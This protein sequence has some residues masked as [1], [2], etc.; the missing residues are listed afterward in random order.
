MK[1][2]YKCIKDVMNEQGKKICE[3]GKAYICFMSDK[4][5]VWVCLF[6]FTG[7]RLFLDYDSFKNHFE[8]VKNIEWLWFNCKKDLYVIDKKLIFLKK[9]TY[10]GHNYGVSS[11]AVYLNKNPLKVHIL[12]KGFAE[13]SFDVVEAVT[14]KE[15]YK[16]IKDITDEYDITNIH[17][18]VLCKKDKIY[19]CKVIDGD[20][21]VYDDNI[22]EYPFLIEVNEFN[23]CFEKVE[24]T[25]EDSDP[26]KIQIDGDHYKDCAIQPIRFIEMNKLGFTQ[27]N[28]V[29]RITRYRKPTGKGLKDLQKI[30]HE[31][32]LLQK[33]VKEQEQ[34][35]TFKVNRHPMVIH[36]D[37]YIRENEIQGLEAD[38]I[39]LIVVYDRNISEY[40]KTMESYDYGFDKPIYSPIYIL[41]RKRTD[42]LEEIIEKVDSLIDDW[43]E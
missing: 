27:G 24:K 5:K 33:L 26:E 22:I 20:I 16:C 14:E 7:N 23:E 17:G 10:I 30:K 42:A 15:K 34:L 11:Y 32:S 12:D 40:K 31:V 2:N 38:I 25:K 1:E 28:V 36:P 3:K 19:S 43:Y 41:G 39:R 37:T 9:K 4:D 35:K 18:N 8:K 29:K 6:P 21:Y 13:N